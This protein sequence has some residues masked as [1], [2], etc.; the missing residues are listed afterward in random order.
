M[1]LSRV[2]EWVAK[3][4]GNIFIHVLTSVIG[5]NDRTKGKDPIFFNEFIYNT[6]AKKAINSLCATC[7]CVC[8]P[9]VPCFV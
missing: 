3:V 4:F 5:C 2:N 6:N 1:V 8:P 7:I 9:V